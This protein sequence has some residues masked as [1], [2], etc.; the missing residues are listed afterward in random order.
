[1]SD[2]KEEIEKYVNYFKKKRKYNFNNK[3]DIDQ[4]L[5]SDKYFEFVD[6]VYGFYNSQ[7]CPNTP[8]QERLS[9]ECYFEADQAI[10]LFWHR[11]LGKKFSEKVK[12]RIK[13]G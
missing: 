6:T 1:M 3:D 12:S 10:D 13:L 8:S 2:I 9:L 5:T 7:L 11:L 4:V